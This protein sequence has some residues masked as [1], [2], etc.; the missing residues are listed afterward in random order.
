MKWYAGIDPGLTGAIALYD[1][2]TLHVFDFPL[3]KHTHHTH[4]IRQRLDITQTAQIFKTY[5]QG[6]SGIELVLL[7][8]VHSLPSDGHVGAFTFG[9]TCG[10]IEG[11]L[12]TLNIPVILTS[13]AVW[14]PQLG[15]NSTKEKSLALAKIKFP[16]YT[17]FERKKDHGRAEAALLAWIAYTKFGPHK[18][19]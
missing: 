5:T 6:V 19:T 14:K 16:G 8:E 4:K 7:E 11:I 17:Y 13:P 2:A 1:G 10:I 12:G 15:L 9:K 18:E 3:I